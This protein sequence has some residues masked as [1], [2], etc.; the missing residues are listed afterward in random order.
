MKGAE[1]SIAKNHIFTFY[2]VNSRIYFW[3]FERGRDLNCKIY[4][5]NRRSVI[6]L[7]VSLSDRGIMVPFL[8]HLAAFTEFQLLCLCKLVANLISG[9]IIVGELIA[10]V[11]N[12]HSEHSGG[13]LVLAGAYFFI[14]TIF[15]VHFEKNANFYWTG[16]FIIFCCFF[17]SSNIYT[18]SVCYL[19]IW[20]FGNFFF[21][22]FWVEFSLSG[23]GKAQ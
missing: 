21:F 6:R 2:F 19:M 17:I 5:C 18:S 4:R 15:F 23:S 11:S 14:F 9:G 10:I 13:R 12:L 22:F 8:L 16:K 3:A 20:S 1:I 7:S